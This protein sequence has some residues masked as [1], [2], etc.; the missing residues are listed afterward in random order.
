MDYKYRWKNG[1]P[2]SR[3]EAARNPYLLDERQ[4]ETAQDRQ[5]AEDSAR[6]QLGVPTRTLDSD[7]P[8]LPVAAP[9]EDG[10]L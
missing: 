7:L 6:K 10:T 2:P 3:D 5:L 8:V 9:P 1:A 4:F